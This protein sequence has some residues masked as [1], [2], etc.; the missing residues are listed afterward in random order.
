MNFRNY[1]LIKIDLNSIDYLLVTRI[2]HGT[3]KLIRN[4]LCI[5][6]MLSVLCKN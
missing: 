2:V 6:E 5:G 1:T 4:E 3:E